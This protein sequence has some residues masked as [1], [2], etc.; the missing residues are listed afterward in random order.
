MCVLV[1]VHAD[2]WTN[3]SLY[4]SVTRHALKERD[5][6]EPGEKCESEISYGI[7]EVRAARLFAETG[8]LAGPG[9]AHV[10]RPL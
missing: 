4:E 7:V 6:S 8:R 9:P 10:T 5:E 3:H 1:C 2:Q